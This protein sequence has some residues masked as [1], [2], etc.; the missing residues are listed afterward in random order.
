MR[1]NKSILVIQIEP[2]RCTATYKLDGIS[3]KHIIVSNKA[4]EV[5][6]HSHAGWDFTEAYQ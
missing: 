1:F 6:S 2:W 5:H 3:Q 4:L